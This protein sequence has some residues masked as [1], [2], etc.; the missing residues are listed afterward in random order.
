MGT[1]KGQT[2]THRGRRNA[3]EALALALAAGQTLRDAA[4]AVG[5]SERTAARRWS[6]PDFRRRVSELRGEMVGQILGKL[7]EG[8]TDAVAKLRELL[9]AQS[10]SVRLGAARSILEIGMRVR[11]LVEFEDR[12]TALE[13]HMGGNKSA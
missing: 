6:D 12:L 3:D 5:I 8:M 7:T 1:E 2:V 11:E 9:G 13:Q 4:Q 10:E